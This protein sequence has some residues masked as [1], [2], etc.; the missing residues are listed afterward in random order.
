MSALA[1]DDID[2][3][4]EMRKQN[5]IKKVYETKTY[6]NPFDNNVKD[7]KSSAFK[8]KK[9]KKSQ[10]LDTWGRNGGQHKS[11]AEILS[12]MMSPSLSK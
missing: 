2:Y 11:S 6:N 3:F 9:A 7:D 5:E 12:D 4:E 1:N 8:N 10:Q